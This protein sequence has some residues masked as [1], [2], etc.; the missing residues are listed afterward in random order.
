[1][2]TLFADVRY[3]VRQLARSPGFTLV[4]VLT[5]ALGAGANSLLFSVIHAVLL[6]P[7][8]YPQSD[9]IVSVAVV[10]R[11]Q[12]SARMFGAQ[13]S[14]WSYLQWRDESR[15]F[16]ELAAYRPTAAV[17][18]AGPAV[19]DVQGAEVTADFFPLFGVQPV[20]GRA[21]TADEQLAHRAAVVLLSDGLWR[22]R[23]GGDGAIVGRTVLMDGQ[24][25]AVIGVL[26]ASFDFPRG[27][28]FWAPMSPLPT[29]GGKTMTTL[30]LSVVG[31]L[32]P[33]GTI[34]QARTELTGLSARS[35]GQSP[36]YVGDA[37][38]DVVT[39]HERLYGSAR[40]LLLILLGAVGFVLLIA[41]ANVASLLV[42]RAASR[43][44]EF[45]IRA[46]LGAGRLR[47][48]RQ[49]LA[50]S[51]VLAVLGAA[52]GL[53]VPVLGLRWFMHAAPLRAVEAVEVH[54]DATVLGFTTALA[55]LTGVA[56]GLAPA[57]AAARANLTEGL[58]SGSGQASA[59]AHRGRLRKG[60][61]VVE[62]AAA[63]V[64]L[65]GAGLLT[66]SLFQL[67]AVDLGYRSDHLVGLYPGGRSKSWFLQDKARGRFYDG[68]RDRLAAL[69]GIAS[70]AIGYAPP[71]AVTTMT[72]TVSVDGVP[73]GSRGVSVRAVSANF[74]QTLETTMIAG[75]DFTPADR[76]GAP[77][78]AIVNAAFAREYL[79]G[80]DPVGHRLFV[81]GGTRTIVGEVKDMRQFGRDLPAGAEV[82]IPAFQADQPPST[83]IL[84]TKGNPAALLGTIARAVQEVDSEPAHIFTLE[85]E[86]SKAAA[87]RRDSAILLAAFAGVALLLVAVGL[88]GLIAYLV[89]YRTHEIGV[90]VALGAGRVEVLRLVVGEG[91]RL[92]AIGVTI[93]LIGAA[94]AARVLANQLFGVTP[95]DP[96]TFV[97]V[98]LVLA[99]VAL[100]A[101]IVP[102]RRATKVDPIV[103]LRYE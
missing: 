36:E 42:A 61:V 99:A 69:P 76:A 33:G 12:S 25:V 102:A 91:V 18:G 22:A 81:V 53:L 79:H 82:F 39:L 59:P 95:L 13:V 34:T 87:P 58:K 100:G 14:H 19:E 85:G 38:V 51:I 68:L 8:P 78:V 66:R 52:A 74:F 93:G 98:P 21:F 71:L 70:V 37:A 28:R 49:L 54:L 5:L 80:S 44:R 7:L 47:L 64:L 30:F 11:D 15:S 77:L 90:R 50:E 46:A 9:R 26:P 2:D 16:A 27:V 24:P 75:R 20:L 67:L 23:F 29:S 10:P 3:A 6:R 4:A 56:F 48:V 96:V 92:V 62:L 97:I 73:P 40:P 45:A 41:C 1:M 32:A 65:V 55:L 86:L 83:F 43:G 84:R 35:K 101:A 72:S 88:A 17:V 57:V 94:A 31:R 103:A 60:L 89:A 63:L